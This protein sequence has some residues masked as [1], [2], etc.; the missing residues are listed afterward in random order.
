M[1]YSMFFGVDDGDNDDNDG[2]DTRGLDVLES[3]SVLSQEA[4]IQIGAFFAKH[5]VTLEMCHQHVVAVL[6]K[7][8]VIRSADIQLSDGC[9]TCH[10]DNTDEDPEDSMLARRAIST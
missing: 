9:Y 2:K 10:V 6:K 5:P 8:V 3:L 7:K 4:Q 1:D